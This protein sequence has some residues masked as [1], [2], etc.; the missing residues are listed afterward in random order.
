MTVTLH[1]QITEVEHVIDNLGEAY[2]RRSAGKMRAS[3]K[4]YRIERMQAVLKTLQWVK[5]NEEL[6]R[7]LPEKNRTLEALVASKDQEIGTLQYEV[8]KLQ[9]RLAAADQALEATIKHAEQE[10]EEMCQ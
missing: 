5:A 6:L 3:E 2:P 4:T 10:R 9:E 1:Q 8:K 7:S